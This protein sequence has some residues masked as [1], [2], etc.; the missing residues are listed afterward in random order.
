MSIAKA[1]KVLG[2]PWATVVEYTLSQADH[3]S[4]WVIRETKTGRF[5]L[6]MGND[7][8]PLVFLNMQSASITQGML[9]VAKLSLKESTVN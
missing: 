9:T 7:V 2:A 8:P 4:R 5:A 3:P 6:D 1:K